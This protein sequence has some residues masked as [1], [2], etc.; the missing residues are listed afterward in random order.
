MPGF[1]H[2]ASLCAHGNPDLQLRGNGEGSAGT[3]SVTAVS[4]E[5][6]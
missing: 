3:R 2:Q 1:F 6:V 5:L 4:S